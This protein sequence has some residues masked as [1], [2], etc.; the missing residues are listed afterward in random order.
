MIR[1][2]DTLAIETRETL[3]V[4]NGTGSRSNELAQRSTGRAAIGALA[5]GHWPR[6][7]AGG[8]YRVMPSGARDRRDPGRG[9]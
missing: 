6:L 1:A 2:R 3:E 7:V 9:T 5:I 4:D 8:R